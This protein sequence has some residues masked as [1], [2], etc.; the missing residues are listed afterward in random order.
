[1]YV[2]QFH[3]ILLNK[4]KGSRSHLHLINK[5]K[6]LVHTLTEEEKNITIDL[7]TDEIDTYLI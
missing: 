6:L 2:L 7:T 4:S 1:M 5:R 3:S